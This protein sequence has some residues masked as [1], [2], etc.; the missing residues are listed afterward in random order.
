MFI[1]QAFFA[2]LASVLNF[3]ISAYI[4]AFIA[5]AIFSWFN[6]DPYNSIIRFIYQI[7]DPV[8][9]RVRKFV[10]LIGDIDIS[11]I[12]IILALI[13]LRSF[14]VRALEYMAH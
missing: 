9:E 4:I 14:L 7:T 2:A 6:P 10:P 1:F 8:L 13:F 3:A 5:R 11:P 12:I